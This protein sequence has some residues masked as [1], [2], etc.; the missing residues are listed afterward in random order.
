MS[1]EIEVVNQGLSLPVSVEG[2][3]ASLMEVI[4]RAAADKDVDVLKMEKLIDLYERLSNRQASQAYNV[5]MTQCQSEMEPVVKDATND[6]TRSRYAKLE[7][8]VQAIKPVYT[9]HGFSLSFGTDMSPRED[10]DRIT[11]RV[12]HQA[13]FHRDEFADVPRD[14]F[15]M[16]GTQNKTNTHAWGS[17]QTYGRRYLTLGIFNLSVVDSLMTRDDDG[18]AAMRPQQESQGLSRFQIAHLSSMLNGTGKTLDDIVRWHNKR[19]PENPASRAED[20]D[21]RHY[22]DIENT[23]ALFKSRQPPDNHQGDEMRSERGGK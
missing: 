11:C 22:Q 21:S 1:N 9:R 4:S 5:A 8:I 16:K 2:N 17:T 10:H 18:Q 12:M 13:G 14:M 6:Q 19:W 20:I 3:V 15:G 7:T 23:V